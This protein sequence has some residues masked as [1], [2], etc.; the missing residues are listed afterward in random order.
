MRNS[1]IRFTHIACYD[2]KTGNQIL[3]KNLPD[4]LGEQNLKRL[5][6]FSFLIFIY[7]FFLFLRVKL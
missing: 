6:F 5:L 7:N 1:M 4:L 2:R 3:S